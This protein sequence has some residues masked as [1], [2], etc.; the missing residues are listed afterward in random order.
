MRAPTLD[1][2]PAPPPGRTGWPWTEAAEPLPPTAPGG[3]PWPGI[4]IVTPS[5][6]QCEYL[7]AAIRSVLLQG[8][9]RLE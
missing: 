9:P 5:M 4:S 1:D 3:V 8:Y 7:E 2:L 6:N